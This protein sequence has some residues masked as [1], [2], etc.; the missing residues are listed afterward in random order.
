MDYTKKERRSAVSVFIKPLSVTQSASKIAA[1]FA[2]NGEDFITGLQI[3]CTQN[4]IY[5]LGKG[6]HFSLFVPKI[7]NK[8]EHNTK[9][10]HLKAED[11]VAYD[12]A[13]TALDIKLAFSYSF[14]Q[15]SIVALCCADFPVLSADIF[16]TVRE[17][18][19]RN[20]C[21]IGP[22]DGGD[23]AL[24]A[25]NRITFSD[26]F[27]GVEWGTDKTYSQVL[28]GLKHKRVHKLRPIT[29]PASFDDIVKLSQSMD[30]PIMVREY[31]KS[32]S[33]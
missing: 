15:N 18:L 13:N 33:F 10:D 12:G 3:A 2:A 22:T 28:T 32:W 8:G 9:Y 4:L 11:V 23:I 24:I 19:S 31:L 30:C 21:V 5:S 16:M 27:E 29:E 25:F 7:N 26:C 14:K 6:T 17:E 20:D 1:A